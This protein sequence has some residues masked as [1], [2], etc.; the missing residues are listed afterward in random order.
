MIVSLGVSFRL[1]T[2]KCVCFFVC[3]RNAS[4]T[5]IDFLPFSADSTLQF[6][7][8]LSMAVDSAGRDLVQRPGFFSR[9]RRINGGGVRNVWNVTLRSLTARPFMVRKLF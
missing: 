9:G 5:P 7:K 6:L 3:D 4:Q 1:Q 2:Q 8:F